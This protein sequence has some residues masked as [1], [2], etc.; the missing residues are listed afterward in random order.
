MDYENAFLTRNNKRISSLA[1]KNENYKS[2]YPV[3]EYQEKFKIHYT[4][5]VNMII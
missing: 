2:K 4:T 5:M 1:S 3:L